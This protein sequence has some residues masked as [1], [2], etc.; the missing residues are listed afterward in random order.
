MLDLLYA[1][2]GMTGGFVLGLVLSA[3]WSKPESRD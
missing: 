3:A 1:H 2:P